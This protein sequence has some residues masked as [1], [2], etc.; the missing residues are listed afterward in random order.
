[1]SCGSIY[2]IVFPNGKHYIGLTTTSIEQRTQG[3]RSCAKSGDNKC[4]YNALRKYNM[5]DTFELT[6]I[7]TADTIEELRELEI[8]Y[9]HDYNSYYM[10]GRGYNMTYGGEGTN[11]Y[12]YTEEDIQRMSDSQIERFK[13]TGAREAH[14]I[15]MKKRFLD[16]PC[17]KTRLSD[18]KKEFHIQ[19]PEE[20]KRMS[21]RAIKRHK[22]HPE[23]GQLH[24]T[25]LIQ[26]Y[27]DHPET[28][29]QASERTKAQFES[30]EA[31]QQMS[32]IKKEFYRQNPEEGKRISERLEAYYLTPGAREK[33]GELQKKRFE[34]PHERQKCS[35]SQKKRFED[36][37]EL[38]KAQSERMKE[39]FK[40]NPESLKKKLDTQG[41][42]RPFDVSTTD[43]TF[44]KTFTYQFEAIE[45][46][47]KEHNITST[48][49]IGE[50]LR[51]QRGSSAGFVFKY[52]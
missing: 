47:R 48:V 29:Q 27:N 20:G 11:G 30:Q 42:N 50:V 8:L 4:L 14:C 37:P 24:S 19:N 38:R 52:K 1:M 17:L 25:R 26:F 21:E 10:N 32:D 28:R 45:Y 34:D 23:E 36:N 33:H 39:R 15:I 18:I 43:G 22:E 35:D 31:R 40:T 44:I 49:K 41:Q 5:V 16:N 6:E 3:H 12:V 9:I 46:L 7:D 2:K 13:K 51:G